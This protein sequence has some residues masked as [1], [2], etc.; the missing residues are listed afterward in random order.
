MALILPSCQGVFSFE[1]HLSFFLVTC[2][3]MMFIL[4]FVVGACV[5]HVRQFWRKRKETEEAA[6]ENKFKYSEDA[7]V[8]EQVV[9]E[10]SALPT[11]NTNTPQV[12]Y[13]TYIY[14]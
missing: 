12:I 11:V 7:K 3:G 2:K 13:A 5:V 6:A 9:G 10:D 4:G 14:C 1:T 8:G